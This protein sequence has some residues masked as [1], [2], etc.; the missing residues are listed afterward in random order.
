[1]VP[2][3]YLTVLLLATTVSAQEPPTHISARTTG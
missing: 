3:L 2:C 1:M